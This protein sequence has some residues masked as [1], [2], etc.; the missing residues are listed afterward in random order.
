MAFEGVLLDLA[1]VHREGTR[2]HGFRWDGHR[3]VVEIR[4]N[5]AAAKYEVGK[6]QG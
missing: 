4:A 1:R 2:S 3:G 5:S 6:T